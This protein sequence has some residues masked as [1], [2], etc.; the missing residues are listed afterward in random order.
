MKFAKH[1]KE[2]INQFSTEE[3][4]TVSI[5]YKS[6]KK[7]SLSSSNDATRLL[8]QSCMQID[9]VFRQH[10][11]IAKPRKTKTGGGG[12]L[13][14]CLSHPSRKINTEELVEF[15]ALNSAAL[16]K[17]CKKWH[18]RGV[19]PYELYDIIRNQHKFAFMGSGE[20]TLLR[21]HTREECPICFEDEVD[22][23][24]VLACGHWVCWTCLNAMTNIQKIKGTLHNRMLNASRRAQCPMCREK[25]PL[26]LGSVSVVELRT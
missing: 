4:R 22:K 24:A 2:R 20:L 10:W 13:N 9:A 8:L 7:E 26:R 18:K 21:G 14:L 25:D 6:W 23:I 5:P 1:W 15:A 3:Y 17:I 16:Y 12:F 11:E 19:V